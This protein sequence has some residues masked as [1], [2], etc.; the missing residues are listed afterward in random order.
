MYGRFQSISRNGQNVNAMQDA[1]SR[2]RAAAARTLQGSGSHAFYGSSSNVSSAT[3]ASAR[4]SG[5]SSSLGSTDSVRTESV[6]TYYTL[7]KVLGR[8]N[9]G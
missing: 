4:S 9:F 5:S 1:A 3:S 8:G 6:H 2:L 7:G